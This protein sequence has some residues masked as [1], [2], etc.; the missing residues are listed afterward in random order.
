MDLVFVFVFCLP[1]KT[2]SARETLRT[3]V[4]RKCSLVVYL[5]KKGAGAGRQPVKHLPCRHEDQSL[6]RR[7]PVKKLGMIASVSYPSVGWVETDRPTGLAE[8]PA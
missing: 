4:S 6:I 5:E 2:W 1:R 3:T 7:P 8:Q